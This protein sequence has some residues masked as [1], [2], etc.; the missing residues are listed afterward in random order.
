MADKSKDEKKK[1]TIKDVIDC[2]L[3][4]LETRLFMGCLMI[5]LGIR[6]MIDPSSA[7]SKISF[8]LGL[9]LIIA[10]IG[11]IVGF[12]TSK[13]FNKSNIVSIIE[14]V[15]FTVLGVLMIIFSDFF[16]SILHVIVWVAIIINCLS[17]LLFILSKKERFNKQNKSKNYKDKYSEHEVVS[18]VTEAISDDF[19]KYNAEF[20]NAAV[21]VKKFADK[22][23]IGQIILNVVFIAL[24]IF[25]LAT[26]FK[27]SEI[28]FF[29]S[30]II[31]VLSGIND[32]VLVYR[33]Y[34]Y[35][36]NR[37]DMT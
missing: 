32:L 14:S 26:N 36:E 12:I 15:I 22:T 20:I 17:E 28:I 9:V 24:G 29:I 13:S 16:G 30:G 18:K 8:G 10:S 11:L 25:M 19:K 4:F 27:N 5:F 3:Y 2:V 6:I 31:M 34:K 7:P 1:V 35:I 33:E 23:L 37:E 21:H